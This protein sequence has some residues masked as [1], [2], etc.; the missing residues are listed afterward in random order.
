MS[1]AAYSTERIREWAEVEEKMLREEL[2]A[3][4]SEAMR[5]KGCDLSP[6]GEAMGR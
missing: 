6:I 3:Q 1:L 4:R 5:D 2:V